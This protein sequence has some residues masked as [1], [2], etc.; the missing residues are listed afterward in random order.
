M[1]L[2]TVDLYLAREMSNDELARELHLEEST[3]NS[4]LARILANWVRV[5]G[6]RQPCLSTN[7]ESPEI[8]FA[9]SIGVSR[10]GTRA[11]AP[12]WITVGYQEQRATSSALRG[13]APYK[14]NV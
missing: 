13:L 3:V 4:H 8:D 11:T 7:Q 1:D 6:Y 9:A 2:E 12:L 10:S 14:V 5:T